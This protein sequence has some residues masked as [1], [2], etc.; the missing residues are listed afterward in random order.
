MRVVIQRVS[1]ASV[2]IDNK[3]VA[4]INKGLLVLVGVEDADTQEDIDWLIAKIAKIRIFGDESNVMNLSVQDVDGDIIVVSQFTLH[5]GTKKGNRPSYIKASKPE[6]AIP[7]YENFVRKLES[8]IG[9]KVQTGEF[10]ADMKVALLNDGPVTIW[11]DSK[12]R[13]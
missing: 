1:S 10:G 11:I 2:T 8:E 9:K 3:I 7:L 6:I 13:E 5:A 4:E 12:N